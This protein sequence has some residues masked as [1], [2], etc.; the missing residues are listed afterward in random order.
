M[1]QKMHIPA[2]LFGI[3]FFFLFTS[4]WG[5]YNS[6]RPPRITSSF[7]PKDFGL[8]YEEVSFQS[9]D[10]LTLKGWFIPKVVPE[11]PGLPS[12]S[13]AL[14]ES[15]GTKR[16]VIALHGYPAD[17]GDV[18]PFLSFLHKDFNLFLFDFRYLGESEGKYTSAGAKEVLD[19]LAAISYLKTRGIEEVGVWGFSMGAAVALMGQEKSP[20]IKAVVSEAAYANLGDL[21]KELYRIPYL[22]SPLAYFTKLWGRIIVGMNASDVSPEKSVRKSAIPILIIHAK[23]DEVISF[24]HALR[25]QEALKN[26]PR[27][28]FWFEDNLTHGGVGKGYEERIGSFFKNNL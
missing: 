15:R 22:N 20:A 23:N 11:I 26:N 25:I 17:K 18:L 27:A 12:V 9:V 16:T 4:A 10:G 1:F 28:E 8:A 21:A 6:I 7:T 14:E 24:S 13:G 3:I 2:I 19:L 5:F